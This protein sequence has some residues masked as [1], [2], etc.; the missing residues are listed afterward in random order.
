MYT[1]EEITENNFSFLELK[2]TNNTA[3]ARIFLDEGGRLQELKFKDIF[4]IKEQPNFEYKVSYASS[5]LFPFA[6]RIREGKYL[7][8]EKEYQL[9]C[10]QTGENALHGLVYNQ[11]FELIS[12]EEST[13]F[14][15]VT[16][17][18]KETKEIKGFPYTYE[19]YATYILTKNEI[20]LSLKIKN[21][22]SKT[23]PFTLGWHPYFLSDDLTKSSLRFKSDQKIEFDTSLITKKIIDHK[24]EAE[25]NI[26]DKQ[27]DDC[28]ILKTNVVQFKTPSYQIE[29]STDK[30][31]NYLQLYTPKGFSVIAI[32]PMTGVSNSFNNKIGL[33][34]LAPNESYAI[35]WNVKLINN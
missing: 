11:K 28:F 23:Y 31:E 34:F 13:D 1:V 22:D 33:Q 27:L 3:K 35:T 18:Y 19:I 29:I 16:I 14:C 15:A 6:S 2:N 32:E 21:T 12:K 30:K 26:E 7:F 10:N 8:Q 5:I 9:N 17:A 24:T 20:T 25:F 4:L